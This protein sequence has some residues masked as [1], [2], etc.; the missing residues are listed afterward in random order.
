MTKALLIIVSCEGK[1]QAEALGETLLKARLAACVQVIDQVNS[2]FLW[3]PGK[4]LIDYADESL[5][6]VKTLESKWEAVEKTVKANHTYENP[7]IIAVPLARV[8]TNYMAWLTRE[9]S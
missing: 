7:E 6:L 8:T 9:L 4:N 1:N 5:L 3:P 2:M